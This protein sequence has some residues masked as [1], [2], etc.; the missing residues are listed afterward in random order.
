[1]PLASPPE[2]EAAAGGILGAS[3]DTGAAGAQSAEV[4]QSTPKVLIIFV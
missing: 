4:S 3:S 1:M 2:E